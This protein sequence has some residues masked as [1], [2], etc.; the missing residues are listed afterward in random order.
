MDAS[1]VHRVV[2]HEYTKLLTKHHSQRE[3]PSAS[4]SIPHPSQKL[5][6]L[7]RPYYTT[8]SYS[9]HPAAS[10]PQG[11]KGIRRTY[12]DGDLNGKLRMNTKKTI[13]RVL[14]DG[15]EQPVQPVHRCSC[16]SVDIRIQ[17]R[18]SINV[19]EPDSL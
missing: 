16:E 11:L 8:F 9:L 7:P 3:P 14:S 4:Y 6:P 18:Y 1:L 12:S 5:A 19:I 17:K 15:T 2:V 10:S 13:R